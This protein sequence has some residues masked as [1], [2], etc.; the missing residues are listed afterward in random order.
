MTWSST[1]AR[2]GA[3]VAVAF[4]GVSFVATK[5]LV[6]EISPWA[7]IFARAGLGSA[8]LIVCLAARG[9]PPPP[10]A[11]WRSLALMGF[12]GVALHQALQAVALT[13]TTAVH[14]GWLISLIPLWS[15]MLAALLLRERIGTAKLEGLALGFLGAVIVVARGRL[16]SGAFGLPS[17]RGDLLFVASTV[18]WAVYSVLG[19]AT[20]RR[21]GPCARP[22]ER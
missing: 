1:G 22:R 20:L 13:M 12:V 4:W 7:L 6:G 18:N 2:A 8:L 15:A 5:A 14:S 17:T 9:E 11:A 3:L 16:D 21:L 19:H 10:R